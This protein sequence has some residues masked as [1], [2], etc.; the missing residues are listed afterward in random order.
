MK[1]ELIRQRMNIVLQRA[2]HKDAIEGLERQ[3]Q[4]ING[5]LA[6]LEQLDKQEPNPEA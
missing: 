2:A 6:V 1:D 5:Q 4:V 3:L